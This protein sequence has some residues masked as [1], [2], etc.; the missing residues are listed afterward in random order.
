MPR[1]LLA[2]LALLLASPLLAEDRQLYWGDTHVHTSNSF[3]AFSRLNR[4]ADPETAYRYAS[5]LPV[6]HPYHRARIR[7]DTP[8]DFLVVADHAEYMGVFRT[9]TDSGIPKEG[10]SPADLA[11]S[12][13]AED[14]I[15]EMMES[16]AW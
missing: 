10:L 5:G 9:I 8:L 4:S 12:Q 16:G 14:W 6:L 7:I 3:D 15:G 11:R 1:V 2:L 13:E